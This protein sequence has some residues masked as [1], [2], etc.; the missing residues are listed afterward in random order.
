MKP[1]KNPVAIN[2]FGKWFYGLRA[3]LFEGVLYQI[4]VH[5]SNLS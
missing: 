2:S 1:S 5:S 4:H 3:P